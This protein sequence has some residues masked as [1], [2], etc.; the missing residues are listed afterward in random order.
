MNIPTLPTDN[1]YKFIAIF[2]L[3]LF[4][5]GVYLDYSSFG[6]YTE[7][8]IES[9]NQLNKVYIE[10]NYLREYSQSLVEEMDNFHEQFKLNKNANSEKFIEKDE[11]LHA[12]IEVF[13]D[14][15]KQFE[16]LRGEYEKSQDVINFISLKKHNIDALSTFLQRTGGAFILVG[17]LLWY[18]LHQ[19]Y[20]DIERRWKGM[21]YADKF[22]KKEQ[23]EK[24]KKETETE[25]KSKSE[26][27]E[28]ESD[29]ESKSDS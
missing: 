21:I 14:K 13:K 5:L 12:E 17:F 10:S 11:E 22:K 9:S 16:L 24:E 7:K 1:L 19:R 6:M 2:G 27:Q 18:Y 8:R 26:S 25:T 28:P 15:L 3:V 20:I 23:Q 4:S 29:T